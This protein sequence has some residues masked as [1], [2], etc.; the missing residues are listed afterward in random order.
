M[1]VISAAI[2]RGDVAQFVDALFLVYIII[3]IASVAISWYVNFRGA[4]PY[5]APLRA[6]TGFIEETTT[7][8]LNLFRRF[9]PPIGGGGMAID[10]SPM[11]GLILLFVARSIVVGLIEG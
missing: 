7:P 6:V 1:S 10:L 4:V 3:V 8:Y 9:L 5:N 11:I 2:D